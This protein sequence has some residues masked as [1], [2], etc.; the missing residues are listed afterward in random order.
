[1]EVM[2]RL[3]ERDDDTHVITLIRATGQRGGDARVC[4]ACWRRCSTI[5]TAASGRVTALP[6]DI[7]V[8]GL[9]LGE[10]DRLHVLERAT[11][12]IHCA[13]S[14]SFDLPLAAGDEHQRRWRRAGGGDRAGHRR[15]RAPAPRRPRLDRLRRRTAR[16]ALPR[17]R[18]RR[19]PDVPQQLR[20]LQVPGR[21]AAARPVRPAAGD[22][23]SEHH[24]G[25]Q[26]QRLDAGVQRHLLAACVRSRRGASTRSPPIRTG[27][28]TSCPSTTSPTASWRRTMTT[29]SGTFALV[30]GERA[31]TNA[32]LAD[33]AAEH[34][35]RQ[36]PRLGSA[37]AGHARRGRGVPA[38]LRR[39][40]QL[41]RSA[42]ARRYSPG[43]WRRRR[44]CRSTSEPSSTTRGA[45]TGA[46]PR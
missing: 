35:G 36:A 37:A 46:E 30:A 23:A 43:E 33:L 29:P 10:M 20:A 14:I 34:F 15:A 26:P 39:A 11:S 6:G 28:S 18:A 32:E 4:A 3:I 41:R 40:R 16:A 21:G 9:G 22:R 8:D 5:R 13:A 42:L 44:R 38:V 31:V 12:V 7:A 17:G 1:M 24:R 27:A 45:P 2:A 25:G 19:R